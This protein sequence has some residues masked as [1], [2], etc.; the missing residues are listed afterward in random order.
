MLESCKEYEVYNG[1]VSQLWIK[2]EYSGDRI[3]LE[4][5]EAL[6]NHGIIGDKYACGGLR[7]VAI[8]DSQVKE[9]AGDSTEGF[10][11]KRFK[12]NITT[13]GLNL[14]EVKKGD[15]LKIGEVKLVISE[16]GKRCFEECPRSLKE[17][18]CDY[19]D[20]CLFAVVEESGEI[21]IGAQIILKHYR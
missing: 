18:I 8:L 13:T 7:Q 6:R 16:A 21:S 10:C 12:E 5:G 20:A 4:K 9:A 15:E 11:I 14:K 1:V 17:E 3:S 19:K 2:D